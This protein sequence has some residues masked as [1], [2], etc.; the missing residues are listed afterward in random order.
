MFFFI[1]RALL[2]TPRRLEGLTRGLILA[3]AIQGGIGAALMTLSPLSQLT[4][5]TRLQ[6]I[7]YPTADVLRYVPG[8][9]D[10]YTNQLRAIGTS[11]DP[12][13]FGGMLMLA[14][15]L[16]VVQWAAPKPVLPK[17]LLVLLALPTA[18]GMLLSLSRASWLGLA[19]GLLLVGAV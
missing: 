19:V 8:P 14:L 4:L 17:S 1:A 7:G 11:V 18:A 12:N 2:S 10:T 5:L 15:A 3:G 16:I 13:V 6:V 9:N